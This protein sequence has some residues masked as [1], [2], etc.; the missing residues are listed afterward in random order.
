MLL[1]ALVPTRTHERITISR[2]I[3]VLKS[4]IYYNSPAEDVVHDVE[5]GPVCS[6]YPEGIAGRVSPRDDVFGPG[7]GLPRSRS[8]KGR[9]PVYTDARKFLFN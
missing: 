6:E 4:L 7:P 9:L 2:R 8:G 3:R 5:K 1:A